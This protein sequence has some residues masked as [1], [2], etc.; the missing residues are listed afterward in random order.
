LYDST[1]TLLRNI[2][3]RL[4]VGDDSE[5][6]DQIESGN[7]CL[8]EMHQMSKPLYNGYR[9]DAP[10]AKTAAQSN[11]PAKLT[12]AMP[13]VRLMVIA[14]RRRDRMG[15]LERGKAALLEINGVPP[16]LVADRAMVTARKRATN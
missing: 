15:A 4:E 5:W 10:Q 6:D 9:A 12:R 8:Y 2:V 13:N 3:Q 7:Q 14:I 16:T 11:L 1:K